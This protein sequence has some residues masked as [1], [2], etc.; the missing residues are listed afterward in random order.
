M[1]DTMRTPRRPP[2][3]RALRRASREPG[4]PAAALA[5]IATI[6]AIA[7]VIKLLPPATREALL[8]VATRDLPSRAVSIWIESPVAIPRAELSGPAPTRAE[9]HTAQTY[10]APAPVE[11]IAELPLTFD[12]DPGVAP[13]LPVLPA[14]SFTPVALPI[15]VAAAPAGIETETSGSPLVMPFAK[16]GS[17]L[18]FAFVKTGSAIKAA[19]SG[20]AGVFVPNP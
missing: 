19:A 16:T 12:R 14:A 9:P 20:T 7:L 13:I 3:R 1:I 15:E 4:K 17:A 10:V 11:T 2:S 6:F 5:I 18:R 8:Q